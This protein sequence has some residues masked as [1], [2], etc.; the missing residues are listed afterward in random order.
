MVIV[1]V[2]GG[3][4]N[5][6]F[7]SALYRSLETEGREVCMDLSHIR[8]YGNNHNGYE[9]E[10]IFGLKYQEAPETEMKRLADLQLTYWGRLKR[11]IGGIRKTTHYLEQNYAYK[12]QILQNENIYLEGYWQ[13]EKYFIKIRETILKDFTFPEIEDEKN[14]RLMENIQHSNSVGIHIRR[15]DYLEDNN[16]ESHGRVCDIKYY[17]KAVEYIKRHVS[18]PAFYVFSDD[19]EWVKEN[20]NLE[21]AQFV[22][23]N[24]KTDSYRDMQLMSICNHQIIAN[25]TFSWWAAW[26]NE[27]PQKI[28]VVPSTWINGMDTPDIWCEEWVKIGEDN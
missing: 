5:Q 10:R 3:L 8:K 9:L 6:M 11:K 26:L 12:P 15:G 19:M 17:Q 21:N 14:K 22:N 28:V 2:M 16:L 13:T 27:N 1:K 25:S 24:H 23:W 18:K 4:G 20:L 7:Q